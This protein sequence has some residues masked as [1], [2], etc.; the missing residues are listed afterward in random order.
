MS[1]NLIFN[2]KFKNSIIPGN[3]QKFPG[4]LDIALELA[5]FDWFQY[6]GYIFHSIFVKELDFQ[7]KISKFYHSWK[8]PEIFWNSGYCLEITDFLPI[9]TY[10]VLFPLSFW[11]RTWFSMRNSKIPSILESSWNCLEL[12]NSSGYGLFFAK[13]DKL[14]IKS[15]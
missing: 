5:S 1:R 7:C 11:P 8:L 13:F 9:S 3:F 10:R 4:T 2:T 12:W 6:I 15:I 14:G